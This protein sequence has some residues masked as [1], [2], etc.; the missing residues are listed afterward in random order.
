MPTCDQ[1]I[2]Y[3]YKAAGTDAHRMKM[4]MKPAKGRRKA[5]IPSNAQQGSLG[6]LDVSDA[7]RFL[8]S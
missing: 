2:A 4:D 3:R 5:G 6:I 1:K 8:K 7:K